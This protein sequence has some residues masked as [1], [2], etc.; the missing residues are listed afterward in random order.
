MKKGDVHV[1]VL[2]CFE[3]EEA[4]VVV[5]RT[6][7]SE[8]LKIPINA[9]AFEMLNAALDRQTI[10]R[11]I[12]RAKKPNKAPEPTPGSVTPRATEGVSK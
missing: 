10:P 3:C 12:P 4:R 7:R 5:H 8:K 6:E 9:D 2:L 11:D 1:D